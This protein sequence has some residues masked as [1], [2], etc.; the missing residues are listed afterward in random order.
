M[1]WRFASEMKAV[2]RFHQCGSEMQQKKMSDVL[3]KAA[4]LL[5]GGAIVLVAA[6]VAHAQTSCTVPG[7]AAAA[8][9]NTETFGPSV[10]LG[11]NW[12]PF[13]YFGTE[14]NEMQVA[15]SGGSIT[16]QNSG[17]G[18]GAQL[19]SSAA[20]GGGGYFQATM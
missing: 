4:M 14:P 17:D 1:S 10:T 8:G 3:R 16:I 19:Q 15:Q 2:T 12:Q 13:S 7:P 6:G 9:Y 5:A 18:Y 11:Q 20:F